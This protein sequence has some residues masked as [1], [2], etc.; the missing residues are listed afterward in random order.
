M[1]KNKNILLI[2][3]ALCIILYL[4]IGIIPSFFK[5]KEYKNTVF[6]GSSTKVIVNG[7]ILKVSNKNEKIRK[8]KV[9]AYFNDEFIDAYIDSEEGDTTGIIYNIY[10]EEGN[11][12]LTDHALFAYTNDLALKVISKNTNESEDLKEI[13]SFAQSQNIHLSEDNMLDYMIVNNLDIDSDGKD[14]YIYSVGLIVDAEE[15][16][17]FVFIKDDNT[18]KLISREESSYDEVSNVRLLFFNLIDFNND[19]RYE[20][21]I[22]RIM[23]EYGP[24]YYDLYDN[25]FAR[26]EEE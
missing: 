7:D 6:I 1:K 23:S 16:D 17:S 8:Q 2:V 9:K 21:V 5:G 12:L 18:Y 13:Y 10:D 3:I 22:E 24:F 14:E 11:A 15:Y 26:I 25:S 20:Y 19:N 4:L